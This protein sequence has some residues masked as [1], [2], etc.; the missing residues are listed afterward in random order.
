M[1]QKIGTKLL[2]SKEKEGQC[3]KNRH[4]PSKIG[5]VGKYVDVSKPLAYTISINIVNPG[6][7]FLASS[8]WMSHIYSG[9]FSWG[10]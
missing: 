10:S 8:F 1:S 4:C 3:N 5:T 7:P 6:T 2:L 9:K